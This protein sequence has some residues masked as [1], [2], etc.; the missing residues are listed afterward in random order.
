MLDRK[1]AE[2]SRQYYLSHR[3]EIRKQQKQYCT[4]NP[5]IFRVKNKRFRD[6]NRELVSKRN[7]LNYQKHKKK[8]LAQQAIYSR[9]VVG[10]YRQTVMSA[11][12]RNISFELEFE[13]YETLALKPCFYCKKSLGVTTGSGLDRV[14]NSLG[15]ILSNLVP[16]CTFCNLL[17]GNRLTFEEMQV[18]IKAL[19][20][21]RRTCG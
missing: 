9:T 12:V 4:E 19:L 17:K 7:R 8:R 10:R 21:Y 18:V 2:Y 15:Y 20:E 5:E 16:C 13:E 11:K 14:D 1:S 6:K 3:K